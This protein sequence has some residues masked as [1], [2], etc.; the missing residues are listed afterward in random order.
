MNDFTREQLELI[1]ECVEYDFYH[2]NWSKSMYDPLISKI[3]AMID[4]YCEH[5]ELVMDCDGG[6][7]MVCKKC[8]QTIMDI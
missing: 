2:S 3:N 7:S 4:N 5:K 8:D 1:A 6:I